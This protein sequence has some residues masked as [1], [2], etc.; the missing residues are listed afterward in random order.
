[1]KAASCSRKSPM[2]KNGVVDLQQLM[3]QQQLEK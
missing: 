2:A 1:M 3:Y